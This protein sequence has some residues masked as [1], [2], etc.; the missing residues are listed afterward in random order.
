[1]N[2]YS[3]RIISNFTKT[4]V[5]SIA[6]IKKTLDIKESSKLE[7]TSTKRQKVGR[8]KKLSL[9]QERLLV[10]EPYDC[11]EQKKEPSLPKG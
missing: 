9:R 1:M 7:G 11:Y 3:Y 5:S 2:N 4:S 8:P 10:G 6:R